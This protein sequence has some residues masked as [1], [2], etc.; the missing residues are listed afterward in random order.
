[1][2]ED[3][4]PSGGSAKS[5]LMGLDLMSPINGGKASWRRREQ[6]LAELGSTSGS[7]VVTRLG[8][9]SPPRREAPQAMLI[10][11]R[12]ISRATLEEPLL[13]IA[14]G[15]GSRSPVRNGSPVRRLSPSKY[16]M[17]KDLLAQSVHMHDGLFGLPA[18]LK[19]CF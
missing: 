3:L 11:F 6:W 5:S 8:L 7:R 10:A 4:E 13:R 1:M 2:W 14:Q 19:A 18:C 17:L 9:G 15:A 12:V 16:S